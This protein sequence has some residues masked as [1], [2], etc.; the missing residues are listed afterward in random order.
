MRATKYVT[1]FVMNELHWQ[2]KPTK[3]RTLHAKD[4]IRLK[5]RNHGLVLPE[6]VLFSGNL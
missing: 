5:T 3:K 6:K 4:D 1:F 2:L